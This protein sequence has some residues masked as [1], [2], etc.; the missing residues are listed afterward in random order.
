M[1]YKILVVGLKERDAGKT[2]LACA[3]LDYLKGRGYAAC[4]FKPRAGNSIWYDYDVVEEA[5]SQG[6]LYGRDAKMLKL[7][8]TSSTHSRA[9]DE[10]FIN[11]F[12]RLWAEP[13]HIDPVTQVPHF[14][15][16]RV[17]LWRKSGTMNLV[18]M[19]D[20]L[21]V[22]YRYNEAL[23][24]R[25]CSSAS[26]IFHVHDLEKLNKLTAEYYNLAAEL[27]FTMMLGEYEFLVIESY[28]DVA[29]PLPCT[30]LRDLDVVIGIKPGEIYVFEPEKYLT[31]VQL[32]SSIRAEE[33]S[34]A[35]IVEL[36]KPVREVRVPPLRSAEIVP[37][38]KK[39]VPLLLDVI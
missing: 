11:P 9:P 10:E 14:I 24:S 7:V 5:L 6:R 1:V 15:L 25:L 4:G 21:P 22:E 36:L 27:V 13:P 12:H 18:V 37:E 34:T 35:E 16:D 2:H 39:K 23:F 26:R 20:A 19:N 38:L 17:T 8:S 28:C 30:T 31:A 3:I 29:L 33:L 32:E